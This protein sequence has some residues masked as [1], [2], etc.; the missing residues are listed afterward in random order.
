MRDFT[1]DDCYVTTGSPFVNEA[2]T[3][4]ERTTR[5]RREAAFPKQVS[6]AYHYQCCISGLRFRSPSGTKW[7][8]NA[9]HIIPHGGKSRSGEKVYGAAAVSNGLFLSG[10]I[11]WCFDQGWITLAPMLSVGQVEGYKVEVATV[12]VEP[13]FQEEVS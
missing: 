8:G 5:R 1:P 7:H 4:T 10:F 11:H 9:A 12:A 6:A 2:E 13:F 3:E